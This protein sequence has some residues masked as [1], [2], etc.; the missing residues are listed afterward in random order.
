MKRCAF[1]R[2]DCETRVIHFWRINRTQGANA[3]QTPA[4]LDVRQSL[5]NTVIVPVGTVL[6]P[7]IGRLGRRKVETKGWNGRHGDGGFLHD[8][9]AGIVP[10]C[11]KAIP[12]AM[13][14][15]LFIAVLS[16]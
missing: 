7:E 1:K 5:E 14:C 15:P 10:V 4:V 11:H 12:Q 9:I 13:G 6:L 8:R 16:N 2:G 3:D